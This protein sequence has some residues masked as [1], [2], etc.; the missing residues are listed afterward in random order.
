[1]K[2]ILIIII[3]LNLFSYGEEE[4]ANIYEQNCIPC[5]R[6][7]PFS[8]EQLY[9]EYLKAFSGKTVFKASLKSFLT[10]PKEATSMRSDTFL[11]RF[12]VKDSTD[13][14]DTELDEALEIYWNLY[15]VRNKLE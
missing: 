13:L 14:N 2:K 4:S 15:D 3:T 5:H 6:Y 7:L 9:I 1:M 8:L 11:D 12:S 10:E